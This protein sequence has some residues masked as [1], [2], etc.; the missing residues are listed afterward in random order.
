MLAD[1][2]DIV[3]ITPEL[4][5]PQLLLDTRHPYKDFACCQ[6]L[7]NAH[8]LGGT[9]AGHGLDEKMH[10]ITVCPNFQKSQ[11]VTLGDLQAHRLQHLIHIF[12]EHDSSVFGGAHDM[13]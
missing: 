4:T 1:S 10:M 12:T 11:F 3:T 9:I 8:D 13:V 5:T 7:D 6:A 2:T